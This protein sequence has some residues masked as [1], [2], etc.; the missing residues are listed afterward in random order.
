MPDL[1]LSLFRDGSGL[2]QYYAATVNRIPTFFYNEIN[3][4][5]LVLSNLGGYQYVAAGPVTFSL[6]IGQPMQSPKRGEWRIGNGTATGTAVSFNATTAQLAGSLAGVFGAVQVA[7]YGTNVTS[8]YLIT[9]ATANTALSLLPE[10]LSLSPACT[11][12]VLETVAPATGVTAQ[13]L[14]RLRRLPALAKTQFLNVTCFQGTSISASGPASVCGPW[15]VTI[16]EDAQKYPE[17]LIPYVSVTGSLAQT[18]ETFAGF[19][20]SNQLRAN[21][22]DDIN[23]NGVFSRALEGTIAYTTSSAAGFLP[24]FRR[25]DSLTSTTLYGGTIAN[26]ADFRVEPWDETGVKISVRPVNPAFQISVTLGGGG[27]PRYL[28]YQGRYNLGSVTF[29]GQALDE[30]FLEAR[31]D[32]VALTMEI[33]IEEAGLKTSLLQTPVTIRRNIG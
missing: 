8:G 7:T 1:E 14:I 12:D 19:F 32:S 18:D 29:G 21:L 25:R 5:K 13:K 23:G 27:A 3:N 33:N 26:F 4:L 10:S 9:A 6:A 11:F 28:A 2:A 31:A 24:V 15:Y 30:E 17:M 20:Y 16:P 22:V